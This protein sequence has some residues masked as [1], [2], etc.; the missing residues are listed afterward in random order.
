MYT[1]CTHQPRKCLKPCW[2][3]TTRP[4]SPPL[5]PPPPPQP[6]MGGP[7]VPEQ[8]KGRRR[9][10]FGTEHTPR[11]PTRLCAQDANPDFPFSSGETEEG[12]LGF[13]GSGKKK[14]KWTNCCRSHLQT[15]LPPSPYLP[16][17]VLS[18]F[19]FFAK[20]GFPF[21]RRETLIR[22]N[23]TTGTVINLVRYVRDTRK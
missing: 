10:R 11:F 7:F 3:I 2:C 19:F 14:E 16:R 12:T 23:P 6:L 1:K 9:S 21:L 13:L 18:F 22:I 17:N 5:F 20:K 4:F 15:H 8:T